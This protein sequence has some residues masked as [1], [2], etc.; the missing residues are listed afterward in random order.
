MTNSISKK[1]IVAYLQA[2]PTFFAEHPALLQELTV[3]DEQGQLQQMATFQARTLQ[4]QNR[5]LKNQ[6]KQ[7]IHHAKL[8]EVLMN[9]VYELLVELAVSD[10]HDFL[11]RFVNF[12][13]DHFA[14]DYFKLSCRNEFLHELPSTI[15]EPLTA[16]QKSQ[17]TV[18]QHQIEPLS[19]RL[20]QSQIEAMFGGHKDIRSA[21]IIPLGPQATY[22]LMGFASCDEE[23]FMPHSAS[24]ILQKL[25]HIVSHFFAAECNHETSQAMS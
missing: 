25:G 13:Q 19:G 20:P 2:N 23:K 17:F 4:H 3:P 14:S 5:Q 11:H 9:R 21:I 15:C 12:V 16:A 10:K 8:N 1:D 7:L 18:F 22:G 6:M 24:D